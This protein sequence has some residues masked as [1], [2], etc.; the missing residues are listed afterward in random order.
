[1]ADISVP[2]RERLLQ[3]MRVFEKHVQSGNDGTICSARI[4]AVTGW[5]RDT[6]RKSVSALGEALDGDA[7][8]EPKALAMS[9]RKAL[10]LNRRRK[11]CVVGLGRLG[12][13]Y[14]G[15]APVEFA[16]FELVAGF[17]SNA[18]RVEALVS[19]VPLY[20]MFKLAEVIAR[21]EIEIAL[22]C[23]PAGAAQDV[24]EKCAA[25]GVR[26]ILNFA[27]VALNAPPG[28]AVHNALVADELRNL[29]VSMGSFSSE[30]LKSGGTV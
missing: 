18:N 1:M 30:N 17:D 8:Y 27:P 12:C 9:I 23:V 26:G 25:A 7:G 3:L 11:F 20:P 29:S 6:V 15:L 5:S 28:V 2:E 4:E 24:A 10:G 22:L 13:A 21:F 14:I 16:E 19:A